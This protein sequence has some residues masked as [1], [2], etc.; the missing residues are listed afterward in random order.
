MT[1][2][3]TPPMPSASTPPSPKDLSTTPST[4]VPSNPKDPSTAI[5]YS[6]S[7]PNVPY[8]PPWYQLQSIDPDRPRVR[9]QITADFSPLSQRVMLGSNGRTARTLPRVTLRTSQFYGTCWMSS[10]SMVIL[11]IPRPYE[12]R[13]Q[14]QWTSCLSRKGAVGHF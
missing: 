2:S 12:V 9:T 8:L 10:K 1:A 7:S 11:T 5:P 4:T 3:Q 14:W 13:I 6:S